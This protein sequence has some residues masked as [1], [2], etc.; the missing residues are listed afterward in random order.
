MTNLPQSL[1]MRWIRS[2]LKLDYHKL[3]CCVLASCKTEAQRFKVWVCI[4]ESGIEIIRHADTIYVDLYC[5]KQRS[6]KRMEMGEHRGR[7][8]KLRFRPLQD[9]VWMKWS[10]IA[11]FTHDCVCNRIQRRTFAPRIHVK[12]KESRQKCWIMDTSVNSKSACTS[13]AY[14]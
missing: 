14:Y 1:L 11:I 3:A 12:S 6:M 8:E 2:V 13:T 7:S 9:S 5:E 4:S 10:H